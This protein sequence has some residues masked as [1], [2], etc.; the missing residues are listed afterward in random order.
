MITR[1][2]RYLS[3]LITLLVLCLAFGSMTETQAEEERQDLRSEAFSRI[4]AAAASF[5]TISSDFVQEKHSSMLKDPLL[6]SGRFVYEKPDRL[7]WEIV[8]PSPAGFVVTGVKAR[9]WEG[10]ARK[11]E[12][13]DVRKEPVARAIVE[14][15][16]AWSRADFAWL[17][18]R[19]RITVTEDRPTALRLTPLSSQEKKYISHLIITFSRDWSHVSS[20]DISEK[21]GDYVR[22]RFFHTLLDEPLPGNLFTP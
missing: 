9:R 19:Y 5:R 22:I 4:A 20:V 11:T 1:P 3:S 14:Q 8:K 10:D 16:F 18:K 6:S 13:F 7:Y 17:E 15:V 12:T 2:Y 21:G